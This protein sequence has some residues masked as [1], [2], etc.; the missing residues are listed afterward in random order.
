MGKTNNNDVVKSKEEIEKVIESRV[1]PSHYKRG[2][3]EVIEIMKDQLTKE[4]MKGLYKGNILKYVLRA[5]YKNGLED[6]TKA[7]WYLN[8]LIEMLKED[9]DKK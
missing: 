5:D 7:E 6:Y 9:L 8:R 2:K 1:N 4:E 3:F